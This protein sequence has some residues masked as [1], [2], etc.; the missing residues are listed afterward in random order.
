MKP[1]CLKCGSVLELLNEGVLNYSW[2]CR[3]QCLPPIDTGVAIS[4]D[5]APFERDG[6]RDR[7][8]DHSFLASPLADSHAPGAKAYMP[9]IL[10][11]YISCTYGPCFSSMHENVLVP[12]LD[13]T[14]VLDYVLRSPVV[15]SASEARD[16]NDIPRPKVYPELF[17][18]LM[19]VKSSAI[20]QY[21]VRTFGANGDV[22]PTGEQARE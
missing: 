7:N 8:I 12:Y 21:L 17:T 15:Y 19:R 14:S 10:H 1:D 9:F 5:L 18:W 13:S 3:G 16:R 4:E 2:Q 20:Q 22:V 11:E 6:I